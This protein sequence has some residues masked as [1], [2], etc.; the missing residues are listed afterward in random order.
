MTVGVGMFAVAVGMIA[1]FVGRMVEA[2]TEVVGQVVAV[3]VWPVVHF[4]G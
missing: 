2:G 3:A 4:P 1:V